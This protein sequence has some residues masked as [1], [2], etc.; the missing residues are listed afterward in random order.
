MTFNKGVPA[1]KNFDTYRM[2]RQKEAPKAIEVHFVKNDIDPTG[3][4][5]PFVSPVFVAVANALYKATGKRFYDQ[6]FKDIPVK[7]SK[8][9]QLRLLT[10]W[11]GVPGLLFFTI[12]SSP[13][14]LHPFVPFFLLAI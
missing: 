7:A 14:S 6:P 3:L 10:N 9:R 12:T 2:I 5:S 8:T 1:K 13:W 4:A 11:P